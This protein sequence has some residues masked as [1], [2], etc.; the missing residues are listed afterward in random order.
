[1]LALMKHTACPVH[2]MHIQDVHI[3]AG[4]GR[5]CV[6]PTFL[7]RPG[8]RAATGSPIL[9]TDISD[10]NTAAPADHANLF[11]VQGCVDCSAAG[12]VASQES[13]QLRE[14]PSSPSE[15]SP[16]RGVASGGVHS[17][18][19]SAPD[20]GAPASNPAAAVPERDTHAGGD[21]R[22]DLCATQ[23]S[24][25]AVEGGTQA[26]VLAAWA[27]MVAE[28]YLRD[29]SMSMCPISQLQEAVADEAIPAD[30]SDLLLLCTDE[31]CLCTRMLLALDLRIRVVSRLQACLAKFCR[32]CV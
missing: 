18:P 7:W 9:P 29:A 5:I 15:A 2:K 16:V 23:A 8:R 30:A 12:S 21:R 27:R 19:V 20:H 13:L 3:K 28:L 25:C 10:P 1:M 4:C 24:S 6:L 26:D 32:C 17:P 31:V 22:Q 11:N 14:H